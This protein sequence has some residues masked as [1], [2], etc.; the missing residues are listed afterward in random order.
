MLPYLSMKEG[1]LFSFFTMIFPK[2]Q[3]LRLCYGTYHQ[4]VFNELHQLG[5]GCLEL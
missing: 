4:K 3:Y 5:L 2:P 1:S